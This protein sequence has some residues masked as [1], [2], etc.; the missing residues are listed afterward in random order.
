L[1]CYIYKNQV[2]RAIK[3]ERGVQKILMSDAA[4]KLKTTRTA[5]LNVINNK[6]RDSEGKEAS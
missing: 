5:V 2:T 6:V 4:K 3:E 1:R